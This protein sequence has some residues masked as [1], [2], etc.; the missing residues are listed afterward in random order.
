MKSNNIENRDKR[1]IIKFLFVLRTINTPVNGVEQEKDEKKYP[2]RGIINRLKRKW[3]VIIFP[4]FFLK[5]Y[6]IISRILFMLM[7]WRPTIIVMLKRKRSGRKNKHRNRNQ[8]II[9]FCFMSIV[10]ID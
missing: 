6:S 9:R 8:S 4:F 5:I 3:F 7:F 2:K 1:T 10:A